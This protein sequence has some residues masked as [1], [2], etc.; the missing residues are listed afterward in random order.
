MRHG[1]PWFRGPPTPP[2]GSYPSGSTATFP[3]SSPGEPTGSSSRGRSSASRHCVTSPSRLA[4]RMRQARGALR[5]RLQHHLLAGR[6]LL[7]ADY[8]FVNERLARHYG[9]PHT[10]RELT[11]DEVAARLAALARSGGDW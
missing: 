1:S 9:V 4:A 10:V 6:D 5:Q 11:L 8:T 7:T 2:P 3:D